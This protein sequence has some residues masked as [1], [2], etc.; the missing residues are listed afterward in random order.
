MSRDN[1]FSM[2]VSLIANISNQSIESD[3][4]KSAIKKPTLQKEEQIRVGQTNRAD[5]CICNKMIT[6]RKN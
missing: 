3:G 2:R 5:E 6:V 4:K 1:K